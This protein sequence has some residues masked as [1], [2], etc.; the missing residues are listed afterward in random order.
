MKLWLFTLYAG[1]AEHEAGQLLVPASTEEEARQKA[2]MSCPSDQS[3]RLQG[4]VHDHPPCDDVVRL[5]TDAVFFPTGKG[6]FHRV[7]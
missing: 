5:P 3:V 1:E 7:A 2:F 6:G 4:E